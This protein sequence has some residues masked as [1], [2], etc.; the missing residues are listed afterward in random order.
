MAVAKAALIHQG[1]F[2]FAW[3]LKRLRCRTLTQSSRPLLHDRTRA[4]WWLG[5]RCRLRLWRD[6]RRIRAMGAASCCIG[7]RGCYSF[8]RCNDIS[9]Y[10]MIFHSLYS[11]YFMHDLF[12]EPKFKPVAQWFPPGRSWD[13]AAMHAAQQAQE[14]WNSVKASGFNRQPYSNQSDWS[15]W[16]LVSHGQPWSAI[17]SFAYRLHCMHLRRFTSLGLGASGT[18]GGDL[19]LDLRVYHRI[20][21]HLC[22]AV[23]GCI[24]LFNVLMIRECFWK[25]VGLLDG[26]IHWGL[27]GTIGGIFRCHAFSVQCRTHPEANFLDAKA[28]PAAASAQCIEQCQA[29][30]SILLYN[31]S[32]ER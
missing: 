29:R 7:V 23:V 5:K 17:A 21:C 26:W 22:A 27:T 13:P 11:W 18:C 14:W 30:I 3:C 8:M 4:S 12:S 19:Q 2:G 1:S 6:Y 9:I 20:M 24:W 15:D 32:Y 25:F 31:L 16:N 28:V 10:S